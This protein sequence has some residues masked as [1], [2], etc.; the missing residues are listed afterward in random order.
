MARFVAFFV[1][2]IGFC[3]PFK[4]V[5]QSCQQQFSQFLIT[6]PYALE[7]ER[8]SLV[9]E[10]PL[11]HFVSM[12]ENRLSLDRA[13]K[14]VE[15]TLPPESYRLEDGRIIVV[16]PSISGFTLRPSQLESIYEFNKIAEG[17]VVRFVIA[18][19]EVGL[20]KE[21]V[22][23]IL[24]GDFILEISQDSMRFSVENLELKE[25]SIEQLKLISEIKTTFDQ[26]NDQPTK[27]KKYLDALTN[28]FQIARISL[29][30][31]S[32]L[33]PVGISSFLEL[34]SYK[35]NENPNDNWREI[36]LS[37]S[38]F[39]IP[40]GSRRVFRSKSGDM[41][42]L[43]NRKPDGSLVSLEVI[44]ARDTEDPRKGVAFFSYDANSGILSNQFDVHFKGRVNHS[45]VN[46]VNGCVSCH[47]AFH[48]QTGMQF[49]TF[50][51]FAV[52]IRAHNNLV[53]AMRPSDRV[54]FEEGLIGNR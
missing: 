33:I 34:H 45:N 18:P 3:S 36:P 23:N 25:L 16:D 24:P 26:I 1:A 9:S 51:P 10:I 32:S 40:D 4:G 47:R 50:H 17:Q 43:E 22:E 44:V 30:E 46:T 12:G 15:Q 37:G 42:I 13:Y 8:Q 49:S 52:H 7:S 28:R 54:I 41:S 39:E 21:M 2:L 11:Q 19:R 31:R 38:F 27:F 6:A 35:D 14:T 20:F 29:G 48:S 53:D 5:A